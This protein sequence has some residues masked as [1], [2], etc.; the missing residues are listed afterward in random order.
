M[1]GSPATPGKQVNPRKDHPGE[2]ETGVRESRVGWAMFAVSSNPGAESAL[3]SCY[4]Y[5]FF[6]VYGSMDSC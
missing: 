5:F 4:Y 1:H 2:K 3:L 6:G